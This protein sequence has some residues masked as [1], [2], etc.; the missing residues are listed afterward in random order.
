MHNRQKFQA[1]R[2][3]KLSNVTVKGAECGLKIFEVLQGTWRVRDR[4][5]AKIHLLVLGTGE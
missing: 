2:R 3:Q 1:D 4:S 5:D